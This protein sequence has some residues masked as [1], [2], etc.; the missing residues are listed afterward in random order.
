MANWLVKVYDK[1][2]VV[3][4]SWPIPNRTEREAESE[5]LADVERIEHAAD[6]TMTKQEDQHAYHRHYL[7]ARS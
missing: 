3:I 5:A 6:W 7:R 4:G 2:N 1:D